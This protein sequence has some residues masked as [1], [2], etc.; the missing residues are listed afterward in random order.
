MMLILILLLSSLLSFASTNF[1]LSEVTVDCPPSDTC[2]QRRSRFNN[3]MG[4]YRSLLHLKETLRV[5]ASDGGYQ[6]LSYE[7]HKDGEKLS[8]RINFKLKPLIKELNIGFT[9][10]NIEHDPLQ[11]FT[12]REGE[13]FESQKLESSME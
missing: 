5:M 13:F 9:D 2:T 12:L 1:T 10:R 8:L 11:L 6:N 7:L 4:D 3:L